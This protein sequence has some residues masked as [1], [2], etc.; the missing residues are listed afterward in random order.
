MKKAPA[1]EWLNNCSPGSVN[2][3]SAKCYKVT[4][5]IQLVYSLIASYIRR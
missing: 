1:I 2:E 3:R 4:R 5:W